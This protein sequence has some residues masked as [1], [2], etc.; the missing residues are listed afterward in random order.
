ML[1]YNK[2]VIS[3]WVIFQCY[4]QDGIR[5]NLSFA[6][7]Y[8]YWFFYPPPGPLPAGREGGRANQILD[9]TDSSY[10]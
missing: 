10:L 3:H 2:T 1:I 8:C 9:K 5:N 6:L 4:T 7:K